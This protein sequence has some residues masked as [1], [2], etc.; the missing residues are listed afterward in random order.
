MIGW[1][2]S[3]NPSPCATWPGS[4]APPPVATNRGRINNTTRK[5]NSE[6]Y[7]FNSWLTTC[8][9]CAWEMSCVTR[10]TRQEVRLTVANYSRDILCTKFVSGYLQYG[11]GKYFQNNSCK[12]CIEKAL[13][14]VACSLYDI[15]TY[16]Y[17][18]GSFQRGRVPGSVSGYL[19][20][21]CKT[22]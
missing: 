11:W 4:F 10:L 16:W 17:R 12:Y 5:K 14:I 20:V 2:R 1:R 22:S 15:V 13:R 6:L 9:A 21:L 7:H 8:T 18:R 3:Q 19:H